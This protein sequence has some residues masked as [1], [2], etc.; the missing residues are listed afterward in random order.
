MCTFIYLCFILFTVIHKVV[1]PDPKIIL[2]ETHKETIQPVQLAKQ[3]SVR[4]YQIDATG[5]RIPISPAFVSNTIANR[6]TGIRQSGVQVRGG[7]IG[8]AGLTGVR[9]VDP[10]ISGI[11][12]GM[13][14]L[15]SRGISMTPGILAGIAASRRT[16][17][18]QQRIGQRY[19]L[20]NAQY[21]AAQ[22]SAEGIQQSIGQLYGPTNGLYR[23]QN[24]AGG[25]QQSIGQLYGPTNAGA[26]GG[27]IGTINL[28]QGKYENNRTRRHL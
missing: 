21:L 13:S 11:Q 3:E 2:K 15:S 8:I 24:S 10:R 1:V 6:D 25:I 28:Q 17:G 20:N 12:A 27:S 9:R 16:H 7:N 22:N 19:G 14:S 5:K 4:Y 26:A 18:G 23:G